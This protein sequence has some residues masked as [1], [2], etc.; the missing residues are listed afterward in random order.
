MGLLDNFGTSFQMGLFQIHIYSVGFLVIRKQFR[1]WVYFGNSLQRG[2][3][4]E[5]V[6][7][8]GTVFPP[9]IVDHLGPLVKDKSLTSGSIIL[10]SVIIIPAVCSWTQG[11]DRASVTLNARFSPLL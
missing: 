6:Y 7:S 9:P 3:I 5:T 8:V 10:I 1:V 2:S 11:N 4:L